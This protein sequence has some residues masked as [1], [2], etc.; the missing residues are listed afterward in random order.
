MKIRDLGLRMDWPPQAEWDPLSHSCPLEIL[1]VNKISR[2]ACTSDCVRVNAHVFV[3]NER[4]RKERKNKR[5]TKRVA[6]G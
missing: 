6:E 3:E 5:R 4:A 2:S 1:L